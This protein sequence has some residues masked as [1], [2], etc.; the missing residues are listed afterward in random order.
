MR[1]KLVAVSLVFAFLIFVAGAANAANA[2]FVVV[3]VDALEE[4]YVDPLNKCELFNVAIE[5]LS[6]SLKAVKA[7]HKLESIPKENCQ[8][9]QDRFAIEF[10]RAEAL[11]N[12]KLTETQLAFDAT[13]HMANSLKDSHVGFCHPNAA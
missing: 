2:E 9:A 12:G 5:G 3:A 1:T 10:S 4:N 11:A 8:Y 7:P 6:E 13:R